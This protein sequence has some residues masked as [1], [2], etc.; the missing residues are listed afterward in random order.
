[1]KLAYLLDCFPQISETFI[2]NEIVELKKIDG[3]IDI[4]IYSLRKPEETIIHESAKKLNPLYINELKYSL[5][6]IF[7][8]ALRKLIV[9]PV[10]VI[11]SIFYFIRIYKGN[12]I[13]YYLLNIWRY[14]FRLFKISYSIE[15]HGCQH[16]HSHFALIT[17]QYALCVHLLT[18]IPYSF[19][20][21]AYDIFVKRQPPQ[22][23][24]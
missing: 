2:L 19:T 23:K 5:F 8:Y 22:T 24:T 1:M 7:F 9:H 6:E 21:H 14:V 10:G 12:F 18:Q 3:S 15:K 11:K 4:S 16:I 17:T 20:S 13:K